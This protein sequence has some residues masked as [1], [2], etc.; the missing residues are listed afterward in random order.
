[1]SVFIY[2]IPKIHLPLIWDK[3]YNK[4]VKEEEESIL[5]RNAYCTTAIETVTQT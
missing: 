3:W 1:M 4:G 5:T 2:G